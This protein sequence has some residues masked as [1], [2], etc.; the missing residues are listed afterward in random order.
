MRS[1]RLRFLLATFSTSP[2][3]ELSVVEVPLDSTYGP[4]L[5]PKPT[6][7]A[8]IA[9]AKPRS[10]SAATSRSRCRGP[11]PHLPTRRM[12]GAA[13]S[14]MDDSTPWSARGPARAIR[15][16]S[17]SPTASSCRPVMRRRSSPC[18]PACPRTPRPRVSRV[19]RRTSRPTGTCGQTAALTAVS[20]VWAWFGAKAATRFEHSSPRE[21][22]VSP[23]GTAWPLTRRPARW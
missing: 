1:V 8:S 9:L 13:G 16:A 5:R 3:L 14:R 6:P 11:S 23:L 17:V 2:V 19:W 7:S 15:G 4:R 12:T 22:T 20:M 10:R 21:A 18:W